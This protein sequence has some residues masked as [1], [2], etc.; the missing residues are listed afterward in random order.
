[1][2]FMHD[3]EAKEPKLKDTLMVSKFS[4]IFPKELLR[5]SPERKIEFCINFVLG[6]QL[7]SIPPYRIGLVELREL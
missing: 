7:I 4:D 1:M 5:L 6:T 3:V 2:A